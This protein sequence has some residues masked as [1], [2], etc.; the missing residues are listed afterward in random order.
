[1]NGIGMGT[2]LGAHWEVERL[3]GN[4]F[5]AVQHS[6]RF[7]YS[8]RCCN[9]LH[10]RNGSPAILQAGFPVVKRLDASQCGIKNGRVKLRIEDQKAVFCIPAGLLDLRSRKCGVLNF[11]GEKWG[12]SP[13]KIDRCGVVHGMLFNVFV[14]S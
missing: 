1:M 13:G 14:R 12:L 3:K 5:P 7:H 8:W 4:R 6:K 10:R 2:L 11:L 9:L